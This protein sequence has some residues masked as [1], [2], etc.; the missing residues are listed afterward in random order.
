MSGFYPPGVN[1]EANP[2][3]RG[4]GAYGYGDMTERIETAQNGAVR[5]VQTW[6]STAH[7]NGSKERV[8]YQSPL[9]PS[10]N[11]Q[12]TRDG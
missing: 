2:G 9:W 11:A 10:E 12:V 3:W 7:P 1:L 8:A 5:H 4:F 6:Y